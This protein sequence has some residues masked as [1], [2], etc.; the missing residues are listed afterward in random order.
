[1][2]G[3]VILFK[4]PCNIILSQYCV[5]MR[6]KLKIIENFQISDTVFHYYHYYQKSISRDTL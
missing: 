4:F 1:M 6:S 2:F 3:L 5:A